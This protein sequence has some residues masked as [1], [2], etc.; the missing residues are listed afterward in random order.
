MLLLLLSFAA[1]HA[2]RV[3]NSPFPV[4]ARGLNA[5]QT[6]HVVYTDGLS[7]ADAFTLQA[8]QGVVNKGAPTLARVIDCPQMICAIWPSTAT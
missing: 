7:P 2:A 4:A 6:L 8:L 1:C 3:P 5:S